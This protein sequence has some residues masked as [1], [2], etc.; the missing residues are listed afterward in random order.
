MKIGDRFVIRY[1]A[2]KH[3]KFIAREAEWTADCREWVS[4]KGVKCCC[5]FDIFAKAPRT[6]TG[7]Y[8]I[9]WV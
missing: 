9:S 4:K 3:N 6:A 7:N 5:Y 2:K 8:K 1:F